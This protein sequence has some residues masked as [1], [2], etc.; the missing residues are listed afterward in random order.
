M[1]D[2]SYNTSTPG[3]TALPVPPG[4]TLNGGAAPNGAGAAPK[5]AVHGGPT[6][7]VP[8]YRPKPYVPP[9]RRYQRSRRNWCCCCFLWI[10]L[11][12]IGLCFLAAI[13]AGVLYV[14]YH[15]RKPTFNVTSLRLETFNVS[16]AADLISARMDFTVTARNPNQKI[17]FS[18]GDVSISANSNNVDVADGSIP[19]F[20]L[21]P[22]NVTI[23]RVSL[24]SSGRSIDPADGQG[25]SKKKSYPLEIVLD[26][27]AGV[28]IGKLKSFK[29]A[30][31][32]T[33]TGITAS[34]PKVVSIAPSPS[35]KL[36]PP[37]PPS[38]DAKCTP[39]IKILSWT[40]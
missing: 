3:Q 28:K 40:F 30:I 22:N 32:V 37:P 11:V 26:T 38:I 6:R 17:S 14:L 33:C 25:L 36:P 15:P 27:K 21:E 19:A 16:Q 23:Q 39:K 34:L 5:P 13:A 9:S 10:T 12:L 8:Q 20:V 1:G 35:A 2:R 4:R 31:R 7:V 18:Y 29:I 24:S